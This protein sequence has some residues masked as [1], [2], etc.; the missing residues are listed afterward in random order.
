MHVFKSNVRDVRY[1]P[2]QSLCFFPS[3]GSR[4][5]AR[6]ARLPLIFRPKWGPKG[7]KKVFWRPGPPLIS[8]SGWPAPPPSLSEGLDQSLFPMIEKAFLQKRR[9]CSEGCRD[10]LPY[11][12]TL[13]RVEGSLAYMPE[14]PWASKRSLHFLTKL[15]DRAVFFTP[16]T[17]SWLGRVTS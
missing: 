1:A 13:C 12:Q 4:G 10:T 5:E 15:G 6:G 17:K 9:T 11:G 2:W 3:G 16:E 8:G 7:R 14:L